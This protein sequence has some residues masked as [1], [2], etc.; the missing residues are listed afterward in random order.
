MAITP[1]NSQIAEANAVTTITVTKPTG[2][3]DADVLV[4]Y[5]ITSTAAAPT[6]VPSGF[7]LWGSVSVSGVV[8]L[9]VY[10]KVVATASGEPANYTFSGFGSGRTTGIVQAF[11]GVDNTTP[12]DVAA[13][14]SASNQNATT[15]VVPSIT[16]T[17]ADTY[18]IGCA[19]QNSSTGTVTMP[20][21][22]TQAAQST[23][24]GRRGAAG[25]A[26]DPT[27]GATGTITW[28]FNVNNLAHIAAVGALRPAGGA[29]ATPVLEQRVRGV[30]TVK[31]KTANATSVRLKI[32][33]DTGV[34]SGVTFTSAQTPDSEGYTTHDVSGLAGDSTFYYRVA[35]TDSGAVETL[36]TSSTVG[37]IRTKA[38]SGFAF[39]FSSCCDASDSPAMSAIAARGDDLFLHLGDLYYA[40]GSGTSVSNFR[41]KWDA[42]LTA[43]NHADVFATIASTFSPSDHDGMQ[44]NWVGTADTTARDSY[45]T[46]HRERTANALVPATTGTYFAFEWGP[47]CFIVCD[48]RSFKSANA[49]TDNGAK[50]VLGAT[51]KQWVKDTAAATSKRVVV[52]VGDTPLTGAATGVDDEWMGYNTER[53]ELFGYLNSLAPTKRVAYLHGDMHAVGADD[54]SNSGVTPGVPSFAASPLANVWSLKG[55]PYSA[56][57]YPTSGSGQVNQYGRIVVSET[58]SSVTLDFT[59]YSADNTA[60]RT[61]TTTFSFAATLTRSVGDTAAASD[62]TSV[63]LTSARALG[64]AAPG[65]DTTSA[66]VTQVLTR[67]AADS[68]PAVDATS[69]ATARARATGDSA[70][71]TDALGRVGT[72]SRALGDSAPAADALSRAGSRARALADVAAASDTLTRSTSRT[73]ALSDAAAGSDVTSASSTGTVARSIGDSAPASDAS[74]RLSSRARATADTAAATDS[75]T[76]A[77]TRARALADS[78][79][80]SDVTAASSTGNLAR[81]VADSA[82]AADSSTRSGTR[83]R[84]AADSA[85]AVDSSTRRIGR[86]RAISDVAAASELSV[87]ALQ[88]A[89]ARFDS[90]LAVDALSYAKSSTGAIPVVDVAATISPRVVGASLRRRSST[91][92]LRARDVTAGVRA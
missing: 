79:T 86:S 14:S 83:V 68:A 33:T 90:A 37:R 81:N 28:T 25:Y 39:C 6:T 58:A 91:G 23:G 59:G 85:A 51:Q 89:R 22:W 55:G 52:I 15:V 42:K 69:R 5:I 73:R 80:T 13:L 48:M 45:N 40:D 74:T 10:T 21:G 43:P 82:P 29:A 18:L 17:V 92:T 63:V 84:S 4:A 46:V 3:V 60:R 53:Q 71:A 27:A 47:I 88:Q 1:G 62:S 32:G 54:G 11:S 38:S 8:G 50:T 64:D 26:A 49:A 61:Q 36:D 57:T 66:S 67:T 7:S 76:R 16:T 44:N 31:V 77:T 12:R 56:G 75:A 70:P 30:S 35:M 72:R 65:S 78:A 41:A 34:T 2:L 19:G 20:S 9:H 24:T 87:R